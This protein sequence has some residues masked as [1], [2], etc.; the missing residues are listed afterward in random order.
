MGK[1]ILKV[2]SGYRE[3]AIIELEEGT[4]TIGKYEDNDFVIPDIYVSR[5]HCEISIEEDAVFLIDKSKNGTY[6]NDRLINNEKVALKSGDII[7]I[8]PSRFIIQ[9]ETAPI[10]EETDKT[11][12]TVILEEAVDRE[13]EKLSIEEVPSPKTHRKRRKK[14]RRF[15][16]NVLV[17]GI[18]GI[19]VVFIIIVGWYNRNKEKNRGQSA[20]SSPTENISQGKK[21]SSIYEAF[22]HLKSLPEPVATAL[23][24]GSTYYEEFSEA[25][26]YDLYRAYKE[27]KKADSLAEKNGVD[28][29]KEAYIKG[30]VE[31]SE[32]SLMRIINDLMYEVNKAIKLGD[33][34]KA[35]YLLNIILQY[36]NNDPSSH[37]Y[38]WVSRKRDE[39]GR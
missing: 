36:V 16:H 39:I 31:F 37:T 38:G 21:I 25:Q 10:G 12:S 19:S 17:Y 20:S 24:A 35:N 4:F 11:A 14:H 30:L 28:R 2:V 22:T 9:G 23:K 29:G 6:V 13:E 1:I 8:G 26:K 18:V 27:F 34:E 32:D 5:H 33:A 7:E 3:G 15:S